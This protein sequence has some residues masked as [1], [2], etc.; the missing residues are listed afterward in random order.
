MLP[1]AHRCTLVVVRDGCRGR[2]EGRSAPAC[3]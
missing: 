3:H 2:R 1:R